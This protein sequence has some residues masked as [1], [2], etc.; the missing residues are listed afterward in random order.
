MFQEQSQTLQ[1]MPTKL[2]TLTSE[3]RIFSE[4]I[5]RLVEQWGFKR[6]L[7]RVWSVMYLRKEPMNPQDIQDAVQI[8]SGNVNGVLQELKTW[9]VIRHVRVPNDR[10]TYYKVEEQIWKSIS[11][12]LKARELRILSEALEDIDNLD[13]ALSSKN[14]SA[15]IHYQRDRLKHVR[16]TIHAAYSVTNMAVNANPS[17]FEKLAHLISKLRSM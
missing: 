9:G 1:A 17:R 5:G 10:K 13:Q 16:E 12:V 3:E 4:I 6:H 8:S 11:N 2:S 7:G 15:D 14:H